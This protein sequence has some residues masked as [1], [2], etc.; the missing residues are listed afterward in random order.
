MTIG[1]TLPTGKS[2]SSDK[3]LRGVCLR[4]RGVKKPQTPFP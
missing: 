1:T 2:L 4:E 3:E